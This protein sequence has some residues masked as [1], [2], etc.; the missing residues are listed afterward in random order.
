M[1]LPAVTDETLPQYKVTL[2]KAC[3]NTL[4]PAVVSI[5][6]L[7][8]ITKHIVLP[9]VADELGQHIHEQRKLQAQLQTT[10]SLKDQNVSA[11]LVC[12]I[13][14]CCPCHAL[15]DAACVIHYLHCHSKLHTLHNLPHSCHM[16][17]ESWHVAVWVAVQTRLTRPLKQANTESFAIC[18]AALNA[19]HMLLSHHMLT[20]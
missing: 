15:L 13:G 8:E 1:L 12:L 17:H 18:H 3:A 19:K 14:V 9:A 4:L 11:C 10:K 5:F 6:A 7:N 2:L 16:F 20:A